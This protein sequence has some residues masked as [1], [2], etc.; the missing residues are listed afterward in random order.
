MHLNVAARRA[1]RRRSRSRCRRAAR[2]AHR[3]EPRRRAEVATAGPVGS[4]SAAR[5]SCVVAGRGARRTASSCCPSQRGTAGPCSPTRSR[6]RGSTT[7]ASSW[8]LRRAPAGRDAP[9]AA[10]TR[11]RRRRSGRHPRRGRSPTPLAEWAPRVARRRPARVAERPP[12]PRQPTSSSPTPRRGRARRARSRRSADPSSTSPRGAR[13]TT[14]R[15]AVFDG[16]AAPPSCTRAVARPPPLGV[17][18]RR[19]RARRLQLDAGARPR[20]VRRRGATAPTRVL[21]NRGAN[22][23]DGVVSTALGVA[24][25]RRARSAC[26]GDLAFLHDAGALADGLGERGGCCVLVVVDNRG[27]G[28]FSFLPQRALGRPV[29]TSSGSS[30]RR[31]AST[32]ATSRRATACDVREGEGPRRARR[33]RRRAASRRRASPSWWPRSGIAI[34][35]SSCTERSRRAA[36]DAAIAALGR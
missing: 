19:R 8:R 10:A 17:A 27:G 29:A 2:T 35:T 5:A 1:A 28:I 7:R 24:S 26:S 13:P 22:G 9:S 3:G 36:A 11:R 16:G 33:R 12:R 21:A 34:A 18:P 14:P 32:S 15:Q 30:R 6:A 4:R 23:I 31:R 25:R 20:V